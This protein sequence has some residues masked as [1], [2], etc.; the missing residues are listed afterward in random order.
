M[1]Q[2]P[3]P[4]LEVA[5]TGAKPA[6]DPQALSDVTPVVEQV[7]ANGLPALLQHGLAVQHMDITYGLRR[8][9]P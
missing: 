6:V 8:C 3:I 5:P 4:M 7:R 9:A 2:S 1:G